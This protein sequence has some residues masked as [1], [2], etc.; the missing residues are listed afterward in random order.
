METTTPI[1]LTT[2]RPIRATALHG[3]THQEVATE[4]LPAGIEVE[5]TWQGDDGYGVAT[6]FLVHT[7]DTELTRRGTWR[8]RTHDLV[9]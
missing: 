3:I 8:Y 6:Q 5:I 9:A 1:R 4:T 7:V 2:T